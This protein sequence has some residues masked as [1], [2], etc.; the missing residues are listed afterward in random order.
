MLVFFSFALNLSF[1]IIVDNS[2]TDRSH[3]MRGKKEKKV[4]IPGDHFP[5]LLT[6]LSNLH[7]REKFT[8][9]VFLCGK[10]RR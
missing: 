1:R 10:G 4:G 2:A 6:S 7:S 9:V 8:D 3:T 5:S